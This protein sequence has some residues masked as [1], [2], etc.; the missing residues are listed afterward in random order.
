MSMLTEDN[1]Q[2]RASCR[3]P[4]AI[5]LFFPPSTPEPRQ[6]RE[7]RENAAKEICRNCPVQTDCL[8]YALRIRESHGIWGGLNEFERK[9]LIHQ[10]QAV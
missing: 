2:L 5:T 3:S 7:D 1:W 10:R 8:D 4:H 9:Q 6:E